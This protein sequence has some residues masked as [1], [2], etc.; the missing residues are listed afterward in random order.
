LVKWTEAKQVQSVALPKIGSGLGQLSWDAEVKP[1]FLELLQAAT[2]E[3]VVYEDFT[4]EDE[5]S[6]SQA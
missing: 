5:R 6:G 3:F 2:C 1:L 4:H